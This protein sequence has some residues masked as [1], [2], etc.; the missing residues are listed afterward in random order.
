MANRK[1]LTL[2]NGI[3]QGI[4]N[5]D[6][7][8]V[9]AG[10][11]VDTTTLVVDSAN[12]RVGIGTASPAVELDVVGRARASTGILFG[13]DTADANAL[14]D[15]E[16]GTWTPAISGLTLNILSATYTKIGNMVFFEANIGYTSGTGAGFTITGLPFTAASNTKNSCSF[17]LVRNVDFNGSAPMA[18]VTGTTIQLVG[19]NDN[20]LEVVADLASFISTSY[21]QFS[22]QF[23][24]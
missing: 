24:V 15:Y 2:T 12:N 16:E 20:S 23:S 9:P 13:S 14:D 17:G 19:Y 1:P 4:D 22:G 21:I 5:S 3:P 7:L 6:T 18:L 8:E 11:I 10:L